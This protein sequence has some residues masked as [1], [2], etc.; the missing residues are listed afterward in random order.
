MADGRNDDYVREEDVDVHEVVTQTLR[1]RG[2]P[3]A[4]D[5]MDTA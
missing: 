3:V 2:L 5:E 1:E 4:G